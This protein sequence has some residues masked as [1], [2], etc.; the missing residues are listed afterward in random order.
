MKIRTLILLTVLCLMV[1]IGCKRR[2]SPLSLESEI[3]PKQLTDTGLDFQCYW[4]PDGQY[5]AFLS[6]RNTYDPYNAAIISELWIMDRDG[7]NQRPLILIDDIY[8]MVTIKNV[9]W[10]QNSNEMIVEVS[11]YR[12]DHRNEIWRVTVDGD[13]T[14]LSAS[15]NWTENSLYSPDG[16]RIAFLIQKS[17]P[18]HYRLYITDTEFSD[19][20]LVAKGMIGD[21]DWK[22]DSEGLVYSL[23]DDENKNYDLWNFSL[24][25]SVNTKIAETS[26]SEEIL[27]CSSDGQY[28]AFSDY[29]SVSVTPANEFNP[30]QI[31]SGARLPQWIPGRNL[32]VLLSE[33]TLDNTRFWTESWIVDLE[34]NILKK[35]AEG[36]ASWTSFS[37]TG[38]FFVYSVNGNIWLDYFP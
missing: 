27:A 22:S 32:I 4:S 8:E 1:M 30:E 2:S 23:F 38:D 18:Y 35:I 19:T 14:Q 25:G 7:K 33:Q 11:V 6:A 20:L 34:G 28:I 9:S 3:E 36:E 12:P 16:S 29:E 37:S 15:G 17:N 26:E 31:I 10:A 21:Y 5:I 13:K 24:N